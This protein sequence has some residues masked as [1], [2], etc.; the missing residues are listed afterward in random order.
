VSAN[1]SLVH[2]PIREILTRALHP[3]LRDP[4]FWAVQAMVVA[5]AIVHIVA[6]LH[7]FENGIL[8]TGA[9]IDP[10]LIPV[11]YAALRYGL[12]GSAATA[13]WAGLLWL[14]DLV[15]PN[16]RGH[17]DQ[18]LVQIAVVIA[19]ALFVGLEIERAHLEQARAEAAEAERRAAELHYH[20]LFETNASPILLVD[21]DGV[22]AEANAA[23]VA[24]WGSVIGST[25][26]RLLGKRGGDLAEG[27]SPETVRLHTQTGEE[28]DYRLSVSRLGAGA[29]GSLRQLVLEDV[30]E[31]Y[32]AG[33][34]ARAWAGEVLRAQEEERRRIARE[35]HDDP[36]QR[37]LQLARR[38]EA[39]GSPGSSEDGSGRIGAARNELLDVIGHLRDVT[40]TLHPAGL[41]QLGLVAA[42]RGLLADVEAEEGVTTELAVTGEVARGTPEA[43]VGVFRIAQ[44]A[45]RNVVRHAGAN[46]LQVELAYQEGVVRMTV[47]D[48]GRGFDQAGTKPGA[49]SHLGILGMRERA[50]LLNGRCEVLSTPGEGTFV[51]ATVPLH[52]TP[53]TS[54]AAGIVGEEMDGDGDLGGRRANSVD[55]IP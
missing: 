37:L 24:L 41:D 15:L 31:E 53:L 49:G 51:A 8:P 25:S 46:R 22:V 45:V 38:M 10:L 7:G 2:I 27:R 55:V 48:N 36:L 34:Q 42:L 14:P 52:R 17:P 40:R 30:T 5:W 33:S 39:L 47:A 29:N 28:R 3:P 44:E 50:S 16:H 9:P 12:S 1:A 4:A 23:A 32:L 21:S 43:E 19:V 20:Q 11:G 26:E 6:D 35:I 13:V 54:D 18:D